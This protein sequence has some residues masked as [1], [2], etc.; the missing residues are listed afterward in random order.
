MH[1]ENSK[2]K[3]MKSKLIYAGTNYFLARKIVNFQNYISVSSLTLCTLTGGR[4]N[5]NAN[6]LKA[7]RWKKTDRQRNAMCALP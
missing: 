1:Q 5:S 6:K 4:M 3:E 2:M 7:N